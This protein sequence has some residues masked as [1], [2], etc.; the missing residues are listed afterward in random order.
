MMKVQAAQIKSNFYVNI[1]PG[2]HFIKVNILP[3]TG[4]FQ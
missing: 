4:V 1:L 2:Q 3:G